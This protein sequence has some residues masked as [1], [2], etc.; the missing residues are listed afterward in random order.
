MSI[1]ILCDFDIPTKEITTEFA[2][3]YNPRIN[4]F[5][6][7][8]ATVTDFMKFCK[9]LYSKENVLNNEEFFCHEPEV[10]KRFEEY[11]ELFPDKEEYLAFFSPMSLHWAAFIPAPRY[12]S[13][14]VLYDLGRNSFYDEIGGVIKRLEVAIE[15]IKDDQL[16]ALL[17]FQT[18]CP[19][20]SVAK[21]VADAVYITL[22]NRS[23]SASKL[24]AMPG[25]LQISVGEFHYDHPNAQIIYDCSKDK[26]PLYKVFGYS[27]NPT[28]FLGRNRISERQTR[29][30]KTVKRS[31][32]RHLF[33]VE[34][35]ISTELTAQQLIDAAAQPFFICKEDTSIR[36]CYTNNVE[37]VTLPMDMRSQRL[38][39]GRFFASLWDGKKRTY[40]LV[41]TSNETANGMHVHVSRTAFSEKHLRRF[42]WFLTDPLNREFLTHVSERGTKLDKYCEMPQF[43]EATRKAQYLNCVDKVDNAGL[44]GVQRGI[45]AIRGISGSKKHTVEVRL[46]KGLFSYPTV[47]KNL[48]FVEAVYNFTQESGFCR[49]NVPNFLSWLEKQPKQ[50][51]KA[52]RRFLVKMPES[53]R[54]EAATSLSVAS[55]FK[56]DEVIDFVDRKKLTVNQD[57][58]VVLNKKFSKGKK[59]AFRIKNGMLVANTPSGAVLFPHEAEFFFPVAA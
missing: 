35:E 14:Q 3:L 57:L 42:V 46:F 38:A 53:I 5:W 28:R 15:K 47:L 43:T 34:L 25:D 4:K 45:V 26:T 33:G 27:E 22:D 16:Y 55:V 9:V 36:G 30:G 39:W 50:K 20:N 17:S 41:D 12:D 51:Y 44:L 10:K 2:N 54:R 29:Q 48:E 1:R 49:N 37:L 56:K 8:S 23:Y 7:R 40:P 58:L 52:L 21:L 31:D 24:A 13:S 59:K 19:V 6:S 32:A 18:F 11:F